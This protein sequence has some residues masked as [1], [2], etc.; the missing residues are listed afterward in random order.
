MC[1]SRTPDVSLRSIP[2]SIIRCRC[3][4]RCKA[5]SWCA[6]FPREEEKK[7]KEEKEQGGRTPP[8]VGVVERKNLDGPVVCP[9]PAAVTHGDVHEDVAALGVK[10]H[11]QGFLFFTAFFA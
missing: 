7:K 1:R 5:P 8:C 2:T 4:A 3:L 11:H 6:L 10:A 9:A